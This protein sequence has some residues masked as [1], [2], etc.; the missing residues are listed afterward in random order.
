MADPNYPNLPPIIKAAIDDYVLNHHCKGDFVMA[1]LANDLR[2]AVNRADPKNSEPAV[3]REIIGYVYNE[4][5][6]PALVDVDG[7]LMGCLQPD[8]IHACKF[9]SAPWEQMEFSATC[10]C[11]CH[12]WMPVA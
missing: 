12:E 3:W 2:G 6:A 1:V 11:V 8:E 10:L 7:W 9:R 5:P 4:V